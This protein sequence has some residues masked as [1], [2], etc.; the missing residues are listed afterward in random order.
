MTPKADVFPKSGTLKNKLDLC[1][2][3]PESKKSLK[4]NMVNGPK[5][6]W[7]MNGNTII[8]FIDNCEGSLVEKSL[9]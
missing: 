8:I 3:T 5:D 1:L 9:S 7:N 6:F 4:S 2:I